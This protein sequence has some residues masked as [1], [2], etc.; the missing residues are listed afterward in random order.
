V[1]SRRGRWYYPHVS[2]TAQSYNYYPVSYLKPEDG[3]CVSALGLGSYVVGGG[4]AHRFCPKYPKLDVIPPE[5]LRDASQ[6]VFRALDLENPEPDLLSGD[7]AALREID[8]EEAEGDPRFGLIASTWDA[9]NDR[10][11]PG[12]GARGPR[13]IDLANILKHEALPFAETIDMVLDMGSR[14]MGTPVEIEYALNLD[15]PGGVPALYL[16]QL[17]PLIRSEG[18]AAVEVEGIDRGDCFIYSDRSMGN[19]RDASVTDV[20]WVD[21]RLFQR[22][23]TFAIASEIEEL[24][25][26]MRALGRRYILVGPG[27]WGTRDRWLGIPVAF[28]QIS[29]ARVIVEADLPEFKVESSLGSHFFHN[30][31]SMNIG[32]FTVPWSGEGLVDWDWLYSIEPARAT[33]HCRRSTFAEPLEILMDGRRSLAAVRKT[34]RSADTA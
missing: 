1:G 4:P 5:R 29:M 19:G 22:S 32:Y 28:T 7:E 11:S 6:R 8:I 33:A 21:P 17:K 27:R 2:G 15:E 24:D 12:L 30:V 16:L 9:E 20:V 13:I 10:L 31:T 14:S 3:L 18:K 34:V 25:K 23:D 26:E